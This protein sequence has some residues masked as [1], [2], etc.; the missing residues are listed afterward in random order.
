M[1]LQA[2]QNYIQVMELVDT[3]SLKAFEDVVVDRQVAGF[4]LSFWGDYFITNQKSQSEAWMN[5]RAEELKNEVR[6]MFQNVSTDVVQTMNLIDTIQL[7]GLDYHFTEEIDRALDHLKDIDMSKYGL[8]EVALHFR[9]LRQKGFN[10][11]SDVFKKYKDN[12]GKF[13]E[14]LKDDAK[15][16]LSLY[17]A[18]YLGTKK[19]TILDEAISFTKDKLTSLLKDLNP[20]F[21]KL[22][23]LTLKTPIQR[24]MKRLFT[25]CYI[26]IY[27][28]EL[29]RNETILELAKLDFNM[30]QCLHQEE[31]RKACMWW[32]KL[33]LDIMHLNFIRERVVECYCWSM[34]I[35][36]EPSCSRARLISTKLLMLITV[37]DD[38]YDSYSTLEESLLLT[39][40]IQRWSP[41]A[42]DRL[43]EYMRDFFLKMLSIFQ[44]LENELAPAEKFR[45]LYLKEQ[46]KIL[47]Q[48]YI[49]E[50]KWRDDNYVPKLEEHMRVSI[51]SVGYVWFYCSFLTGMEEAVATKDAF[52][53]FASFPK[54]V[55]ACAIIVRITNDI[56]S[57]EREQKREHV[58]STV[59]CYMKEYAT[60][61]DVACEKL[62]GF[63]EDAWK[64]I[65]EELLNATGLSREVIELSLHSSRSTELIYKHVDAFT[66]PNTTMKE[67]IFSLLVHPIP[68]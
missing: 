12:E 23:S 31:L 22:V 61:K 18:A 35:R 60:S 36:H 4:D 5:E 50:C 43:P 11:S 58:A 49:T 28:D 26:S 20:T 3:P 44:E 47:A 45:I 7:L 53:W 64:T 15:G 40:A 1:A 8:Y 17:N 67:N 68:I 34:V 55:E 51:K 21:A 42:V 10:I 27:Q 46:W 14:K 48:H 56:T 38:I 33:N 63:V 37:L 39:D 41:D 57:K 2:F 65:N 16:L 24:N 30:L 25:R 32:K 52:E 9:L 13:M 19:E 54:I 6:S 59:D 62:L 66:E 29:T